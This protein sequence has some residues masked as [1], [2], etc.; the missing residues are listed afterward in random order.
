[1]NLEI[2]K[3]QDR[4][5]EKRWGVFN[6]YICHP[7]MEAHY[8]TDLSDWNRTVESYDAEKVAYQ[9]H[10]MGAGYYFITLVHGREYMIAPNTAYD[11]ICG[12]EPGV[13]CAK[14]DLVL[15]LYEA[16]KKYDIDLCLYFNCL[17]PYNA[18]FSEKYREKFGFYGA[19]TPQQRDALVGE[20][21]R[22]FVDD[23]A[24]V[25]EE[26]SV[27]YGDKVKAWWLDSCYE[28]SGYTQELI[29]KY[30]NA[31]KKGNP[32]AI[33]AFNNGIIDCDKALEVHYKEEEY[34]CGE[35][36]GN[37]PFDNFNY[38]PQ[39]RWVGEAQAHLL[40]PLGTCTGPFGAWGARGT[41]VDHKHMKEYLKK[42]HEAGGVLTVDIFVGPDGTFDAK[43]MEVLKGI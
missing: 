31:I 15:D 8:K 20:K 21:G 25:L 7:G 19:I 37:Q 3:R 16:L 5:Y 42:L 18:T 30:Y 39:G 10:E 9:L 38:I 34:T 2:K 14:R 43:Q 35:C 28:I 36:C 11:Q 13:L 27:R 29:R 1:M 22:K 33:T 23:W 32:L 4:M 40:T 6:H 24:A 12:V 41:T 17:S 26:F